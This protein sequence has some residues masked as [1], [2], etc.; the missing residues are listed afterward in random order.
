MNV[1]ELVEKF[2]L[3]V[4]AEGNMEQEITGGYVG[5]L[6]SNVMARAEAGQ[7]WLTIQGHQNT[8]AVALLTEVAAVIV[9]E[10][11]DVEEKTI[12][13]GKEKGINILRTSK[14]AY[15]MAGKLYQLGL[16]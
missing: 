4:L 3:E 6:L 5:D 14:P 12:V 10:D 16:G 15:E 2:E 8:A 11:F 13:K 1:K 9:V 7:V